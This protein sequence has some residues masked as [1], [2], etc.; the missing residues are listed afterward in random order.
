MKNWDSAIMK[1]QKLLQV[2][3]PAPPEACEYWFPWYVDDSIYFYVPWSF[4]QGHIL[5]ILNGVEDLPITST[6]T[7]SC[8]SQEH[9]DKNLLV[10][11]MTWG[12]CRWEDGV[13]L[14]H[15][16]QCIL[17]QSD[18]SIGKGKRIC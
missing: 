12:V 16:V 14:S 1:L 4:G 8:I 9:V 6:P 17:K 18:A 11:D 10:D 5:L 13:P 2:G 15:F 7:G 3:P